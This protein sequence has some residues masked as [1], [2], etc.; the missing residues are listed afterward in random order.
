MASK[1]PEVESIGQLIE[2]VRYARERLSARHL[3]FRGHACSAW[4]VEPSLWYQSYRLVDGRNMLQEFR[5]KAPSRHI[6]C[7]PRKE[8]A[9]WLTLA[10]HHRLPCLLLDWTESPLVAAFF[11][12]AYNQDQYAR[13][14]A[15]IWVLAPTKL[16]QPR[17]GE[18]GYKDTAAVPYMTDEHFNPLVN[19]AFGSKPHQGPVCRL[20]L[21]V[22][23]QEIDP[24]MMVQQAAFTI[25]GPQAKPLNKMQG[26]DCF[27]RKLLIPEPSKERIAEELALLGIRESTLFPDLTSLARDLAGKKE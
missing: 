14:S 21:A 27:L 23:C 15:T 26:S 22:R 25:H 6:K 9:E 12:A 4:S 10:R 13:Q 3:W 20:A 8:G 16:N 7:P 2:A 11:A 19:L 5:L 24:K 18:L 1:E 17:L